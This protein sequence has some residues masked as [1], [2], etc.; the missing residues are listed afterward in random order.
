M[1]DIAQARKLIKKAKTNKQN[2]LSLSGL[3]LTTAQL[4]VLLTEIHKALPGLTTLDLTYNEITEIPE[5]IELLSNLESLDISGNKINKAPRPI[6]KLL[7]LKRL[8]LQGNN[9]TSVANLIDV[10]IKLP[11]LE[12]L[13]DVYGSKKMPERA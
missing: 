11:Q 2:T 7:K 10:I 13:G 1:R 6:I 3:G 9:I 12:E 4:S 5:E 8:F